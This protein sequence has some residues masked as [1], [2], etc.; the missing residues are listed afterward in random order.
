MKQFIHF[1][2]MLFFLFACN[3]DRLKKNETAVT[4][5][6]VDKLTFLKI[7]GAMVSVVKTPKHNP[8]IYNMIIV[9]QQTTDSNAAFDIK[10]KHEDAY[11]YYIVAQKTP[12]FYEFFSYLTPN[13]K[14]E[15]T[16]YLSPPAYIKV[17]AKNINPF[18]ANDKIEI[19]AGFGVNAT[20]LTGQNIDT[21]IFFSNIGNR[22]NTIACKLTRNAVDS[23]FSYNLYTPAYDTVSINVHY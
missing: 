3:K 10:F 7:P 6:V 5:T 4:G 1:M 13:Q 15:V 11:R 22:T 2:L 18:D 16:V 19:A 12:Y 20:V 17:N 14:N 8:S 23:I 21:G 9:T